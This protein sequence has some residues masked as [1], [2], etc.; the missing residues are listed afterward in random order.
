MG[1]TWQGL[2]ALEIK[3]RVP[4]IS[5]KSFGAFVAGAAE[6]AKLVGDTGAGG[7]QNWIG[8][9]GKGSDHVLVTLDAISPEAMTT[10]SCSD[11]L[12]AL[13]AEAAAFREIWRADGMALTEI[14]DGKPVFT[15]RVHFGYTGGISM[16]GP[17]AAVRNDIRR[18]TSSHANPG[19][20]FCWTRLKITSY[21]HP[22][23]QHTDE[24]RKQEHRQIAAPTKTVA[25]SREYHAIAIFSRAKASFTATER[26]LRS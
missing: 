11:R 6:R 12:C 5:F 24:R 13:F 20:S 9:F 23:H 3:D 16:T 17:F 4:T 10:Y 1:I 7:P 25:M 14:R 15:S 8:T 26:S 19:Y 18:I 2:I 22:S 21:R